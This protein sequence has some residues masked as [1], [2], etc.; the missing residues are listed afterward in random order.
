MTE[1]RM[2]RLMSNMYPEIDPM[3]MRFFVYKKYAIR[4]SLAMMGLDLL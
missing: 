3:D 4:Q 1:D 2:L